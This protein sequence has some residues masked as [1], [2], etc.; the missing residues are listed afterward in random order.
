MLQLDLFRK[1]EVDG[2]S[3][4]LPNLKLPVHRWFRYSAGFSAEWVKSVV[5]SEGVGSGELVLDPFAGSGT[6]L[7]ACDECGVDSCGLEAHPFV[8]RICKAKL[9]WASSIEQFVELA[10]RVLDDAAKRRAP[11]RK[12]PALLTKCYSAEAL[13]SLGRLRESLSA[14]HDDSDAWRLCWLVFVGCLRACSHAGTAQWQYVLPKKKKAAVSEVFGCFRRRVELFRR[15]MALMQD[16]SACTRAMVIEADARECSGVAENSVRL[17]VTSP[18]Y[19][20][21]YD[22]ADATRLEMLLLEEVE[23]WGDL[24]ERV[25][26]RL[27]RSCTQHVSADKL[28]F[29]EV[30]NNPALE[31]LRSELKVVCERLES[32]KQSHGGKKAYDAMVAAYFADLAQVWKSLR[33]VCKRGAAAAFVIGDSAPYGVYLPVEEWLG[34]LALAAGFG[35]WSFEKWRDRNMKWKNR[36]HRVPLKEG[37][38]W[39]RA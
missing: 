24:Q 28:D 33:R 5:R 16:R 13:E 17:V 2:G 3:T 23:G 34:R 32:E 37:V 8:S 22:Y 26:C 19:A 36:K 35:E 6:S 10:R 18:P 29:R 21:N 20:N 38:L 1:V 7:I 9:C 12:Y 4:F 30:L 31:S 25:R 14:H 27:M 11:E 39:V 15:D